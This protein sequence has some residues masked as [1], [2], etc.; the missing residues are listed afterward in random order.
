MAEY[1]R[2]GEEP[3]GE[4]PHFGIDL[5]WKIEQVEVDVVVRYRPQKKKSDWK[6]DCD[7]AGDIAK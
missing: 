3:E 1:L 2:N 6:N 4:A 7:D 5:C